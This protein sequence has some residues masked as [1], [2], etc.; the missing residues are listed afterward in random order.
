M[1]TMIWATATPFRIRTRHI[2]T[3]CIELRVLISGTHHFALLQSLFFIPHCFRRFSI[4][5]PQ[6]RSI[7]RC[8][9]SHYFSLL[10]LQQTSSLRTR[11]LLLSNLVLVVVGRLRS[12]HL[13]KNRSFI[14]QARTNSARNAILRN[15]LL[16]TARKNSNALPHDASLE[17]AQF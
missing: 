16:E 8:V 11:R 5:S 9:S 4:S 12:C 17:L 15:V 3:V 13:A 14:A 10:A 6:T 1:P 7:P 2:R